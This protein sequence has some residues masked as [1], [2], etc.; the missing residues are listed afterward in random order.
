MNRV[1]LLLSFLVV[2]LVCSCS[3]D[4]TEIQQ[5]NEGKATISDF[6]YIGVAHNAILSNA[7]ANFFPD[8]VSEKELS[9][10]ER[11]NYV[12]DF[13]IDYIMQSDVCVEFDKEIMVNKIRYYKNLLDL[14]NINLFSTPISHLTKSSNSKVS[15]NSQSGMI[16]SDTIQSIEDINCVFLYLEDAYSQ[17]I[18]TEDAYKILKELSEIARLNNAGLTTDARFQE[19]IASLISRVDLAE[20]TKGDPTIECV[21]PVLSI[22]QSSMTWWSENPEAIPTEGKIAPW[23]IMDAAGA[24]DGIVCYAIMTRQCNWKDAGVSA[25]VSGAVSSL[26]GTMRIFKYLRR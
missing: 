8:K 26:G 22:V 25:L 5:P 1:K 6:S 3:H 18:I 10:E 21:G 23:V 2:I 20:Y 7:Q 16:V 14:E 9:K 17:N 4:F 13:N 11:I 15:D 19:Q 24:I 12:I